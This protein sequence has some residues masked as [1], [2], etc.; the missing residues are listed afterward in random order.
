MEVNIKFT[1]VI[2]FMPSNGRKYK[3]Y[4][5]NLFYFFCKNFDHVIV[6]KFNIVKI[7]N[8]FHFFSMSLIGQAIYSITMQSPMEVEKRNEV[9]S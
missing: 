2:F 1:L 8:V 7:I 6:F 9:R 4:I 5:S 3:V